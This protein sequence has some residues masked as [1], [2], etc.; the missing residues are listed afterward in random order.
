MKF[1]VVIAIAVK[2][3]TRDRKARCSCQCDRIEDNDE[4]LQQAKHTVMNM[5]VSRND[6]NFCREPQE[7]VAHVRKA[8]ELNPND[9]F[10]E[11]LSQYKEA[12]L[13]LRIET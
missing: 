7:A 11:Q 12:L 5:S 1:V 10:R 6:E 4:R 8:I 13:W 9:A 3:T 2:T